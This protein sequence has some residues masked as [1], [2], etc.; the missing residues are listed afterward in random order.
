MGPN[1]K[2]SAHWCFPL[3]KVW[4]FAGLEPFPLSLLPDY[5]EVKGFVPPHT[6]PFHS[7]KIMEL[8]HF[9]ENI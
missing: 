5:H 2:K 3:G 6:T 7:P 1:G 4:R 9:D 8:T